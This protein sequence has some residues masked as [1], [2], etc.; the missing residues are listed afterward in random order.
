MVRRHLAGHRQPAPLGLAN[1]AHGFGA[2]DVGH[3]VARAGERDQ[4]QI[5]RDHGRL[6]RGWL[7]AQADARRRPHPRGPA[8]RPTGQVSS[9]CWMTSK[10][11]AAR[12]LQRAAHDFAVHHALCR[13]RKPRRSRLPAFAHLGQGSRPSALRDAADGIDAHRADLVRP[14][15]DQFGDSAVVVGRNRVRH[16]TDGGEASRRRGGGARLDVFLVFLAGLAQVG[17]QVDKPRHD[18]HAR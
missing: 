10:S 4:L 9:A 1:Q 14:A 7:A 18:P 12:V 6:G 5:A 15:H 11:E 8:R 3:V 13:R 17:V 16:G 2:A